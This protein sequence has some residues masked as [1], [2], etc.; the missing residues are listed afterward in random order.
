MLYCGPVDPLFSSVRLIKGT[1]AQSLP[2]IVLVNKKCQRGVI[3]WF[4]PLLYDIR[5]LFQDSLTKGP[6]TAHSSS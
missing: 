2:L 6:H 1:F 3:R 5:L 4:R